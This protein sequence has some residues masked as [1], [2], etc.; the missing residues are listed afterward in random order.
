MDA[1]PCFRFA[2]PAGIITLDLCGAFVALPGEI[3]TRILLYL[4]SDDLA[5]L[6]RCVGELRGVEEDAYLRRVWIEE[7]SRSLDIDI[8]S[9][10]LRWLLGVSTH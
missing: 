4:S 1:R 5:T 3:R 9:F 7:V 6:A 2:T 10:P 8:A